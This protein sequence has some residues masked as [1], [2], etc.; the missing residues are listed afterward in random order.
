[1][2]TFEQHIRNLVPE[3]GN[4]TIITTNCFDVAFK[5]L[6][7]IK[8]GNIPDPGDEY[9]LIL[10]SGLYYAKL[11]DGSCAINISQDLANLLT[12]EEL[13]AA[14]LHEVGHLVNEDHK[15]VEVGD[16]FVNKDELEIRADRYALDQGVTAE[17]LWS[18][19]LKITEQSIRQTCAWKSIVQNKKMKV[20]SVDAAVQEAIAMVPKLEAS[21][22]NALFPNS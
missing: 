17:C 6:D 12:D 21:R 2:N 16:F 20:A 7:L 19:I 15:H 1:M 8:A 13:R 22:Y 5:V 9:L 14:T 4:T 3:L 18:S 10:L 11:P